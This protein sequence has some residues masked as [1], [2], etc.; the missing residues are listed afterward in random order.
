[1]SSISFHRRLNDMRD[2]A[3]RDPSYRPVYAHALTVAHMDH[4]L[5]AADHPGWDRIEA[6]L[7]EVQSDDP[8]ALNT[9]RRELARLRPAPRARAG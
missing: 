6:A 8:E 3:L 2:R 9:L 1:M 7:A 4:R 5:I